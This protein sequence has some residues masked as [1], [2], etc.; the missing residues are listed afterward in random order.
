MLDLL[1]STSI[2]ILV[3]FIF[4]SVTNWQDA[5][6]LKFSY[7]KIIIVVEGVTVMPNPGDGETPLQ[8]TILSLFREFI[9]FK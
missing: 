7:I 8:F 5:I 1:A 9:L 3:N 2:V 6:A 4:Y